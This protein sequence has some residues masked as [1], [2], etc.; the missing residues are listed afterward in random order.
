MKVSKIK[1]L[2]AVALAVAISAS[3]FVGCGSNDSAGGSNQKLLYNVGAVV[4][5]IDPALNTAVDGS[6]I[7]GNA[8]EGL[9]RLD[10]KDKAIP[11]VAEKWEISEDG[12]TYTFHLRENAKWSDGQPVKASDFEYAWKRVLNKD[13]ASEYAYQLFYLKN[14][15]EYYN[16][17]AKADDVGVKAK[18][19]KTLEVKINTKTPYFLELMAFPTYMPVRKDIVEA[20][21]DKWTQ[22]P[23]TFVTNGPFKLE[24]YQMKDSYKFVKN[25]NYWNKDAIKLEELT[26][27][28]ATD[29]TSS[30]ASL[31]SGDFDMVGV[32]PPERMEDGKE[33]G[34]VQT[35]PN[36]GTYF[37]CLNVGNNTDKLPA[38][39]KKAL[40]N[41]DVRHALALA[42]DR[43]AIV[44]DVT[45]GGQVP[46]ADFVPA[47]IQAPDG[48][49]FKQNKFDPTKFEDNVAE[50]KKLLEKAGYKDG[51]GLPTF[52]LMYNSEGD[53]KSVMEV[54][55]QNWKKIGVNVELTNQEWAVFLNTRQKGE[56]EISRHGWSADYVDPMTFLDMW[57]SGEDGKQATWGNNDAHFS[58]KK[59]DELVKK[60]KTE[61]DP[62]KRFEYMRQADDVLMDEMP[63]IP[64]Y[65]YTKT[66]GIQPYV[67]GLQV[68]PLGQIYFDKVEIQK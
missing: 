55:Q 61:S 7:I 22:K 36:L 62:A 33:K 4:E 49:D 3:V 8:F 38:D 40:S 60:A 66:Y 39:V 65:D 24:D 45:K 50:A 19:D 15:E 46:S 26:Y 47:G 34:L 13:T 54:I 67:K 27:K 29:S 6:T 42:I 25:D 41:K 31:E 57:V 48:K 20:N 56:Y 35:F 28:M 30:Y 37:I 1:K 11:G 21:G 44:K 10:D 17:K 51:K 58:N 64:L 14:G 63:I 5:T 12:K 52:K 9:V 16:G 2:C 43:E 68:S 23:E 18:D 59:Y 53:H 32:V